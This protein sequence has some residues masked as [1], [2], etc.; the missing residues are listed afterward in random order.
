MT[1]ANP[2][3]ADLLE[4]YCTQRT[5]Y[6]MKFFNN[7]PPT[8]LWSFVPY[9]NSGD[10]QVFATLSAWLLDACDAVGAKPPSGFKWTSHSL[11]KG[12]ASAASCIGTPLHVVKYMGG[13]AK[14]SSVTEGKYI[15]PTMTPSPL[16]WQYFGW[17]VPAKPLHQ[18]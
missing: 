5:A 2:V 11:R 6:C 7:P 8:A 12:A 10:W 13:G 14:N 15:D 3:L 17:L 4:Y 1:T 16:A 18:D 9:E